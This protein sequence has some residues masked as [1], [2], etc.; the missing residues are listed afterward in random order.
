MRVGAIGGC[1][2]AAARGWGLACGVRS[3]GLALTLWPP[4]PSPP[5]ARPSLYP[6]KGVKPEPLGSPVRVGGA[7]PA[8]PGAAAPAANPSR[9][10][11][12]SPAPAPGAAAAAAG[13]WQDLCDAPG[14]APPAD[15]NGAP[16]AD[17]AA[18]GEWAPAG[19]A[20]DAAAA[21]AAG[22]ADGLPVDG[23]GNMPF[24]LLDAYEN[25]DRTDNLYLFGKAWA[26]GKWASCC[27]V[28][29]NMHRRWVSERQGQPSA[30]G[31]RPLRVCGEEGAA[32][33]S[34]RR[35]RSKAASCHLSAACSS[36]R[37]PTCLATPLARSLPSRP[38]PRSR[39]RPR[40]PAARAPRRARP[41]RALS[42]SSCCT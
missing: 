1:W 21:A 7:P 28:V 17:E 42:C 41:T 3:V 40:P 27:A 29:P 5:S 16:P 4:P 8:A 35:G 34:D 30:R 31:R 39:P 2:G 26:Q 12:D 25:P 22:A 37:R 19:A 13:G 9:L 14:G 6:G 32:R 38:P 20:G 18:D 33:A 10:F 23:D 24:Y 36:C 15:A 11:S